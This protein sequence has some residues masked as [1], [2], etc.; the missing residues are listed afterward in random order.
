MTSFRGLVRKACPLPRVHL[1]PHWL[2]GP[3]HAVH[4]DREDFHKAQVFGVLG[5]HR[6]EGA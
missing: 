5:E 4:R 2:E 3:L 1:P 6:R